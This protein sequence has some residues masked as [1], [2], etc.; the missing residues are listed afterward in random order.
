MPSNVPDS[1]LPKTD[2]T[3]ILYLQERTVLYS[4]RGALIPDSSGLCTFLNHAISVLASGIRVTY[5]VTCDAPKRP[6]KSMSGL[7]YKLLRS[8]FYAN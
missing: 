5:P 1:L 8:K 6:G 4:G 3:I 2:R 7:T